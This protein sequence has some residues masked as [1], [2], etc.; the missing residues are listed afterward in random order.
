MKKWIQSIKTFYL[1]LHLQTKLLLTYLII[2]SIPMILIAVFLYGKVYDMIVADTIRNEQQ[3]SSKTAPALEAELDKVLANNDTIQSLPFYEQ[4]VD[5][6]S[7][8]TLSDL[9][10]SPLLSTFTSQTESVVRNGTIKAVR[11]YLDLPSVKVQELKN[12]THGIFD[13]L[14]SINNTYWKGIFAG[15]GV[16]TLHCP[17]F[18][19]SDGEIENYG[20]MAYISKKSVL[21]GGK[22]HTC[23]TAVYYSSQ[24]LLDILNNSLPSEGSVAYIIN[25]RDATITTTNPALSG[26]YY[27]NYATIQDSFMSSNNFLEKTV[28]DKNIYA[29]MY[30]IKQPQWYM[31][32][33]IPS[34]PLIRKSNLLM[35]QYLLLFIFCIISAL[36]IAVSLSKSITKRIAMVTGQMAKVRTGPPIPLKESEVHDEIGDLID[37]Y[38]YMSTEMNQLL[39]ERALAAEELRIAE[40]N[41]L[42]A[43]INP[44]F[45]YNTMDMINWMASQGRTNEIMDAVQNLSRFYKLTLSKKET[46]STIEQEIEHVTI[47]IRLQNMRFHDNIDLVVDI[48]DELLEYQIPK[49]TLQPVVENAILHGIMEKEDKA[50]CIVLNGWIAGDAVELLVSDDG[51]G[52]PQEKLGSLLTGEGQSKKG[53]NIAIYN[54]HHRLQVLY[55]KDYGL[56]YQS[57]P[58]KGTD[59]SI[60]L[61]AKK[62]SDNFRHNTIVQVS[63]RTIPTDMLS[64]TVKPQALLE[65][66]IKKPD[67]TYVLHNIHQISDKLPEKEPLYILT[68]NV[69]EDFP[70]HTHS[71]FEMSYCC[72]GSV[73]NCIDGE[74][75]IQ[76]AGD[77]YLL[78]PNA[79]QAV[80]KDEPD[81]LLINLAL[82]PELF[83]SCLKEF[84]DAESPLARF[85]HGDSRPRTNFIYF[86]MGHNVRMQTLFSSLI[87][88]YSAADF[89]HNEKTGSLLMLIFEHLEASKEYSYYGPN[90]QTAELLKYVRKHCIDESITKIASDIYESPQSLS[91]YLKKHTGRRIEDIVDETKLNLAMKLLEKPSMNIY[92]VAAACGY[93]DPEYFFSLFRKK[94]HISPEEYRKQFL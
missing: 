59:V 10:N 77:L 65:T 17:P 46:I 22:S 71:Y 49:L 26:T 33:V 34:N 53:S 86:P 92:D 75:L 90:R 47:Y 54:T 68:H 52:I 24:I 41:S 42:Q 73:I 30:N 4:M 58:G 12:A 74:E 7:T 89:H 36:M 72:Q 21:I 14:S 3:E 9:E 43:Q 56:S 23:Y 57:T 69:T 38:N 25:D 91:A 45:L 55:G 48:P 35:M 13:S 1:N 85:L 20:D 27:L 67:N 6:K 50:G 18:Y 32:V 79:V 61:P 84:Y 28:V 66:N 63:G 29:G 16:S 5:V 83:H 76:S 62:K 60:H 31:V 2:I 15:S 44:H 81:S 82:W 88:E 51:I 40:F 78:N 70:A 87:Q 93:Q 39:R 8:L 37:T 19:L 94:F 64:A 80:K 11:I